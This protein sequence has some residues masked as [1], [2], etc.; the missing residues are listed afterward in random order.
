MVMAES[1][2]TRS[3]IQAHQNLD[4]VATKLK[5]LNP[6]RSH[7]IP[8][9]AWNSI[10]KHYQNPI[11]VH[12]IP[13]K[14]HSSPWKSHHPKA[15]SASRLCS[16]FVQPSEAERLD[17]LKMHFQRLQSKMVRWKNRWLDDF[18]HRAMVKHPISLA[19]VE[20]TGGDFTQCI[21]GFWSYVLNVL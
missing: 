9:Q 5:S 14:T 18:P 8:F 2:A 15:H 6:I 3:V 19:I 1:F 4:S 16:I 13:S 17:S 11:Q 10:L 21:S 20:Q 12:E 7:Q